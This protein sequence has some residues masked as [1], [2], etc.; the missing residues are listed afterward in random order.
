MAFRGNVSQARL[1][2]MQSA[3]EGALQAGR[4]ETLSGMRFAQYN[5]PFT[6]PPLRRNELLIDIK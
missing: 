2:K 4:I 5:P 1:T 6:P 3:F